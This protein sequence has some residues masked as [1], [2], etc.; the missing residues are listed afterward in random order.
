MLGLEVNDRPGF[1]SGLLPQIAAMRART[2][3]PH[4]ILIDE[5]H[6]LLPASSETATITLPQSL[7]ATIY[8]T[9]HPDQLS[10]D[11]LAG[12]GIVLAV[13]DRA[14]EVVASF[15]EATGIEQPTLPD[16]PPAEREVLFWD[17]AGG[18]PRWS[19][20][21]SR[22]RNTRGTPASMPK[23]RSAKTRASISAGRTTSSTCAP[24]T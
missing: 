1:F 17:R 24:R 16:T 8:V 5:A 4:W 21:R 19:R 6:H 22:G 3:R 11:A 7:P 2:G 23:A 10:P 18:P 12:V 9:V 15:C 13:G 14:T 20:R